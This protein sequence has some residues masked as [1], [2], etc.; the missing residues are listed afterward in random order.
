[1]RY[2]LDTDWIINLLAGK[3]DVAEYIQRFDPEDIGISLV[4]VAEI[5]ESAFNYANPEAH[6]STFAPASRERTARSLRHPPAD[7]LHPGCARARGGCARRSA[8]S[9]GR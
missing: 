6:I 8:P 9:F 4:T 3:K 1:M 5:Y 7:T 2:I